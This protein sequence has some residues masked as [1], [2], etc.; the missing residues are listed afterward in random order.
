[1]VLID[2]NQVMISNLMV[3]LKQIKKNSDSISESLVRHMILKSLFSYEKKYGEE[4][5]EL[6]LAYD[7]RHYWRRDFFPYYKQNRKKDRE[8]SG[9]N[10]GSIFDLLNKIR[11]EIKHNLKWKVMEV[12][13]A[14]A[15]DIISTLCMNKKPGKILI[16]SGDKDFIQLQKYPGVTQYNPITKRFIYTDDPYAFIKEHVL[17]GDKSDG[18]PN[19]LS[20]DDTFVRGIRQK[21]ISQKKLHQW[22]DHGDA[23]FTNGF[24]FTEEEGAN[25][26]R[27]QTLIDFDYTPQDIQDKIL[28]EFETINSEERKIPIKYL[29]DNL[30]IDLVDNFYISTST[31]LK[32]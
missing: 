31:E 26:K 1:M 5:G 22:V 20:P 6:I 17:K 14:E 11:D 9:H 4:Y 8:K 16:L 3:H 13:G 12:Y 24:H 32:L 28:D 30:L 23:Y 27:N 7:S 25:Y 10:W 2:M 19:F 29:E 15:D 21:P 18:I